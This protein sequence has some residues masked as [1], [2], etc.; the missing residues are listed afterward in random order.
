MKFIAIEIPELP[1]GMF[2]RNNEAAKRNAVHHNI[3]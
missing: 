1:S 2:E 3:S